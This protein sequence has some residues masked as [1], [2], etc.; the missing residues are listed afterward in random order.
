MYSRAFFYS[1]L[2]SAHAEV[3]E[4]E[5]PKHLKILLLETDLIQ[6][7]QYMQVGGWVAK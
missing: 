6:K 5:H 7:Q 4:E 2:L 1:Q 3:I